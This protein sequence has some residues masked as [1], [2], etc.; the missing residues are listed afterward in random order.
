[1]IEKIAAPIGIIVVAS[2]TVKN[3]PKEKEILNR[4]VNVE[5]YE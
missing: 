1:V 5:D 3:N 2:Q 4:W